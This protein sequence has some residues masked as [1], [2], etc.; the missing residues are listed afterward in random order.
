M[1]KKYI[2]VN[3]DTQ[4][5]E[6]TGTITEIA[7][8]LGSLVTVADLK[9]FEAFELGEKVTLGLCVVKTFTGH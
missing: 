3:K 9:N 5:V 2:I 7:K 8:K 1:N 4:A 6:A